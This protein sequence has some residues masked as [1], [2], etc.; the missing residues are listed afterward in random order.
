MVPKV[1][2][3]NLKSAWELELR[4]A[5]NRLSIVS[6]SIYSSSNHFYDSW[7]EGDCIACIINWKII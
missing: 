4:I 1:L 6:C 5:Q 3:R 7:W 2:G